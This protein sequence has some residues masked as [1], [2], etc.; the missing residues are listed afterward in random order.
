MKKELWIVGKC[1]RYDKSGDVY[2]WGFKGVYST[3][4]KAVA[5]CKSIAY[6]VGPATLDG[7]VPEKAGD[8]KRSFYPLNRRK[9]CKRSK[10]TSK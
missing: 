5:A 3:K 10:K 6:F 7:E 8:W 4:E 1:L 9:K 2:N